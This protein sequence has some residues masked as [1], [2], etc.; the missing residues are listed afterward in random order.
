MRP[1]CIILDLDTVNGG[2]F[3]H[4]VTLQL[5]AHDCHVQ[6][7]TRNGC[8]D[9]HLDAVAERVLLS[10][11]QLTEFHARA[12]SEEEKNFGESKGTPCK[13]S[14]TLHTSNWKVS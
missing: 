4:H 14:L 8:R 2:K 5:N 3:V 9:V 12:G 7:L 6:K 10:R 13:F 1:V 11:R